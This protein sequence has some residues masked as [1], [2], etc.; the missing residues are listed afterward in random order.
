M[1]EIEKPKL[2]PKALMKKKPAKK[3]SF[4]GWNVPIKRK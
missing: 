4:G 2:I 1:L 3:K